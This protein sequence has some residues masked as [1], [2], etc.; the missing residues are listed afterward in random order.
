MVDQSAT[1]SHS[2]TRHYSLTGDVVTNNRTPCYV[3]FPVMG[4]S[5]RNAINALTQYLADFNQSQGI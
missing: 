2:I 4:V 1:P 5:L 3:N